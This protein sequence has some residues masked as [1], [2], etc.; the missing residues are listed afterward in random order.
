MIEVPAF[1]QWGALGLLGM[2]LVG[3][4]VG[5]YK[6]ANRFLDIMVA[7]FM[8]Q[9]AA[10]NTNLAAQTAAITSLTELVRGL[11]QEVYKS[12]CRYGPSTS[13]MRAVRG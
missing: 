13:D 7:P 11:E 2:V 12:R 5:L 9:L 1:L 4:G 10:I 6:L 8:N 3:V